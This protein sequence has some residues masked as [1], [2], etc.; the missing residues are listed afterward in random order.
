MMTAA[1]GAYPVAAA[2]II[3]ND[4][5]PCATR[6]IQALHAP[7]T[8][9]LVTICALAFVAALGIVCSQT[10]CSVMPEDAG[11]RTPIAPSWS[12]AFAY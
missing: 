7:L 1:A 3:T 5:R 12:S 10:R 9:L 6:L 8:I 11:K 2:V 4:A